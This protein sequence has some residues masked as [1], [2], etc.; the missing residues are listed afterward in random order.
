MS[1]Q[2]G[3][4]VGTCG[5]R[6]REGELPCHEDWHLPP[7]FSKPQFPHL[8]KD[9]GFVVSRQPL[10]GSGLSFSIWKMDR[11]GLQATV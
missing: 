7:P 5:G 10:G 3:G 8:V 1:E 11:G 4:H 6:L 9:E 2:V